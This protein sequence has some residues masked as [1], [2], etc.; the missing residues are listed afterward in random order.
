[1]P[2]GEYVPLPKFT[3]NIREFVEIILTEDDLL[4]TK[5]V[6]ITP[7]PINIPDP[8]PED[9]DEYDFLSPAAAAALKSSRKDPKEDQGYKTYMSKKRYAE[10]IMEIAQS[11]EDTGRVVGF[12]YW[13]SLVDKGLEDQGRH[14]DDDAYDEERLPG[15]G[16]K[17]AKEFGKGYFTDGL[18][19]GARGYD[20]LSTG[21]LE[22]V[23]KKWPELE[24][25]KIEV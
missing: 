20:V 23:L 14:G 17:R 16:L 5:I 10:K 8:F 7:P 18:H 19:L 13:K 3:Y 9:E 2:E 11:Y 21:L 22:L 12:D 4:S 24:P 1:L 15:C 6:L 25:E